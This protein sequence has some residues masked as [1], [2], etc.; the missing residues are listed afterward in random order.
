MFET[1]I[2]KHFV[3]PDG[4][5]NYHLTQAM[6]LESTSIWAEDYKFRKEKKSGGDELEGSEL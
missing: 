3:A 2:I 4:S 1:S 6:P 5:Q